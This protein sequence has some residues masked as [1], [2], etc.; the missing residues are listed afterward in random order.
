MEVSRN[1][2]DAYHTRFNP[3]GHALT[4]AQICCSRATETVPYTLNHQRKDVA[5]LI[6]GEI[7]DGMLVWNVGIR[8]PKIDFVAPT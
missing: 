7:G 2:R 3:W 4:V 1:F 8:Q 6:A 5:P